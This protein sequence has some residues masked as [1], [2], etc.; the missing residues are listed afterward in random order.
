MPSYYTTGSN[1]HSRR[2]SSH[3]RST[4]AAPRATANVEDPVKEASRAALKQAQ[5]RHVRRYPNEV[6]S[7]RNNEGYYYQLP[8]AETPEIPSYET[9]LAEARRNARTA[10]PTYRVDPASVTRRDQQHYGYQYQFYP[11]P[12][13]YGYPSGYYQEIRAPLHH[14]DSTRTGKSYVSSTLVGSSSEEPLYSPTL[15]GSGRPSI[16]RRSQTVRAPSQRTSQ[17]RRSTRVSWGPTYTSIETPSHH[18]STLST[19]ITSTSPRA[20]HTDIKDFA[21]DYNLAHTPSPHSTSED[22]LLPPS[23]IHPVDLSPH[24]FVGHQT[25][26]R[27]NNAIRRN[28]NHERRGPRVQSDL[29]NRGRPRHLDRSAHRGSAGAGEGSDGEATLV[30][31]L[32][33]ERRPNRALVFDTPKPVQVESKWSPDSSPVRVRL[34]R[35]IK[36]F[37]IRHGRQRMRRAHSVS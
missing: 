14:V 18:V 15:V 13:L 6:R 35:L 24:L 9:F 17:S 26:T 2:R 20:L 33:P 32:G 27:R 19:P 8:R 12:Y 10:E 34:K 22:G 4:D 5:R 30:D 36:G 21:E 23:A 16:D 25:Y 1:S 3:R 11:N 28:R 7:T 29:H 31:E 37:S